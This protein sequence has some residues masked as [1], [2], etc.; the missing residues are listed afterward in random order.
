MSRSHRMKWQEMGTGRKALVV[1]S[2]VVQISLAVSAWID[3]ARRPSSE[4]R[5]RK[6]WWALLIGINFVGPLSYFRWGRVST[7]N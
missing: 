2:S 6:S 7:S 3:L 5:G 1:A 4:V